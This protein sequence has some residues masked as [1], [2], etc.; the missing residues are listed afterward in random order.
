MLPVVFDDFREQGIRER[1]TGLADLPGVAPQISKAV[2]GDTLNA[3]LLPATGSPSTSS[4][5]E[6]SQSIQASVEDAVSA[7]LDQHSALWASRQ[8]MRGT[9]SAAIH[10]LRN[11]MLGIHS[12]T[13][14]R[15]AANVFAERMQLLDQIILQM[16]KDGHQVLVYIPPYRDDIDG[17]YIASQYQDFKSGVAGLAKQHGAQ[18]ADLEKVVPGPQWGMVTDTI[19]GFKEPDFMHFTAAGHDLFANALDRKLFELGY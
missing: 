7:W 11:R 1:I 3:I 5:L 19:F 6:T 8:Q 17:P 13:K 12:N 2:Y 10:L 14:R 9:L 18:F 16:R 4:K 15:V